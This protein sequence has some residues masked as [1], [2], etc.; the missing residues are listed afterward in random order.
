[1]D[2][3]DFTVEGLQE[4]ERRFFAGELRPHLKTEAVSPADEAG[5]LKT[6]KAASFERLVLD[7][8]D[9]KFLAF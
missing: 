5:P 4:F 2:G 1:Y 8:G 7:N 6:V 9:D 3:E